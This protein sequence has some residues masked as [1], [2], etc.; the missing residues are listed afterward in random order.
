MQVCIRRASV[1]DAA[2]ITEVLN[3]LIAAGTWT[4][5]D[6]PLSPEAQAAF[7]RDF[8]ARGVF[9]V[10]VSQADG[11]LVGLQDV[12]PLSSEAT[13]AHVG[14]ISTFVALAV[15][16]RGV[17]LRLSEV[18]FQAARQQGFRKISATIRADNPRAVAFYRRL[19]FRLIGILR[20]HALVRGGYVD[21]VLAEKLI[22]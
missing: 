19:G 10:A 5:M 6:T 22:A 21:E 11:A 7:I 15:H 17:G 4:V 13:F 3:P 18:T 20:E 8:P 12:V 1:A 16:G 2:A 9:H 14:A